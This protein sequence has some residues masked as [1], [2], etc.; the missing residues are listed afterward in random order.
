MDFA[1]EEDL[2]LARSC[3]ESRLR[4]VFIFNLNPSKWPATTCQA[5][6][7]SSSERSE[8]RGPRDDKTVGAK[9]VRA[10]AG[11]AIAHSEIEALPH[12]AHGAHGMAGALGKRVL[13][14]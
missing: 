6:F 2:P 4:L 14:T 7:G 13:L 3:L 9:G 8:S 10:V 12:G 11:G 5:K 1:A